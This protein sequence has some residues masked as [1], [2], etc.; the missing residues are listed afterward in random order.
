MTT[1][2][3]T[4]NGQIVKLDYGEFHD[5]KFINCKMT[6]GGG[7]PPTLV[8]NSFKDCEWIF[9]GE[10]QNTVLFLKAMYDSGGGFQD[11]VKGTIFGPEK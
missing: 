4:I 6:Y 9:E 5:T 8:G 7:R 11:I 3:K 10:A 2:T 1:Q